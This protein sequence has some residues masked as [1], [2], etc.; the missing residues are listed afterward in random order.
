MATSIV[1]P[2][3]ANTHPQGAGNAPSALSPRAFVLP[4][5]VTKTE[6]DRCDK[7]TGPLEDLIAAGIVRRDQLPPEG[8]PSISWHKGVYQRRRCPQDEHYLRVVLY[9]DNTAMVQVG[10]S[11]EVAAPRI[12]ATRAK[13]RTEEAARRQAAQVA[14]AEKA[15]EKLS[16]LI[17]TEDC[18]RLHVAEQLRVMVTYIIQ[19]A[20]RPSCD[21]AYRLTCEAVDAIRTAMKAMEKAVANACVVFD[22][23]R[24]HEIVA[25]CTATIRAADPKFYAQLDKLV[26]PNPSIIA[27]EKA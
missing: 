23:E 5:A 8:K 12:A 24:H 17:K 25:E 16:R 6:E 26:H 11:D 1:A 7:Y 20:G 18:F 21:H 4:N 13:L 14:G 10:V 2:G 15:R 19:T 3:G 22:A 27:G 9:Q